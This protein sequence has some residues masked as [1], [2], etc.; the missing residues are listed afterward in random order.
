MTDKKIGI[1]AANNIR[2]RGFTKYE[3]IKY[4]SVLQ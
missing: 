1:I 2:Y 4:N 3:C